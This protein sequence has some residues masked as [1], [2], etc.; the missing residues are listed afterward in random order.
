[1]M[2]SLDAVEKTIPDAVTEILPAKGMGGGARALS[3]AIIDKDNVTEDIV[4]D[5]EE[6]KTAQKFHHYPRNSRIDHLLI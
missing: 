4:V 2:L 1:M 5:E 3:V 6:V